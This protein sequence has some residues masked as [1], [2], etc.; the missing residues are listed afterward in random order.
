MATIEA[1]AETSPFRE[2]VEATQAWYDGLR[3]ED[4]TGVIRGIVGNIEGS[5]VELGAS[6]LR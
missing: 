4:G 1:N 3:R 5:P 6:V 2:D